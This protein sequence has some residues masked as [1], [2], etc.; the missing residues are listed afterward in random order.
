MITLPYKVEK[1]QS[2]GNLEL[3]NS[4][5]IPISS[6]ISLASVD[7]LKAGTLPRVREHAFRTDSFFT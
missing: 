7:T 5:N 3:T 6:T 1:K 4:E 2:V